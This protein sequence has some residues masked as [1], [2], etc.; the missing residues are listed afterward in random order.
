MCSFPRSKFM[1]EAL[2]RRSQ[3]PANLHSFLLGNYVY[4]GL[5]NIATI[6][7]FSIYLKYNIASPAKKTMLISIVEL[8]EEAC[9]PA[10][11][12]AN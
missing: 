12:S 3:N 6:L 10:M 5:S 8:I 11:I 7:Y 2:Y 9:W 4:G 1:H